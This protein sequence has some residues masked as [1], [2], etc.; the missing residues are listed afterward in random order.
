MRQ[1][2][3]DGVGKSLFMMGLRMDGKGRAA[4]GNQKKGGIPTGTGGPE[5]GGKGARRREVTC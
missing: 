1:K 4:K 3:R 5:N 2:G